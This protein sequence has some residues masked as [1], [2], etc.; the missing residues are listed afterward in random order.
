MAVL[1]REWR[2]IR[3]YEAR[4]QLPNLNMQAVSC[5]VILWLTRRL[6]TLKH[7]ESGAELTGT[8]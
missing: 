1:D 7:A 3:G 6:W 4:I 5:N 2:Q 8:G